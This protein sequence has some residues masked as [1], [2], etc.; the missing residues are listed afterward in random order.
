MPNIIKTEPV[1]LTETFVKF[2]TTIPNEII[3]ICTHET[4]STVNVN[5]INQA[6]DPRPEPEVDVY[7]YLE[8][9]HGDYSGSDDILHSD[10]YQK[11]MDD[12]IEIDEDDECCMGQSDTDF[13]LEDKP[14]NVPDKMWVQ[15]KL[16]CVDAMNLRDALENHSGET[17]AHR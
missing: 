11:F 2:A 5:F 6:V 16:L 13:C 3:T 1:Q 4:H 8:E 10:I 12:E 15:Y 9:N 14:A 7:E 17:I